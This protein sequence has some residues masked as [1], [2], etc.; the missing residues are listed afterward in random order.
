[1]GQARIAGLRGFHAGL[2][3]RQVQGDARKTSRPTPLIPRTPVP[4]P[5]TDWNNSVIRPFGLQ[6]PASH[7]PDTP[8]TQTQARG[9]DNLTALSRYWIRDT[10]HSALQQAGN[11]A[12]W[13]FGLLRYTSRPRRSGGMVDAADSKSAA[14]KSVWVRVPPSAPESPASRGFLLDNPTPSQ[15]LHGYSHDHFA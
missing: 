5:V 15:S 4:T 13:V 12:V 6:P 2:E 10:L 14:L 1:M 8:A 7:D 11:K 3:L 9:P